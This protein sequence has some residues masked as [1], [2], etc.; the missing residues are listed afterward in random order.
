MK[1]WALLSVLWLAG[2]WA[3]ELETRYQYWWLKGPEVKSWRHDLLGTINLP[4]PH[5]LLFGV[6]HFERFREEDRQI[7][8]GW[9]RKT[10]SGYWELTHADGGHNKVLA[11][12]DTQLTHGGPLGHGFDGQINLKAQGYDTNDLHM[13][14]VGLNKEFPGGSFIYTGLGGGRATFQS[15]GETQDVWGA[16]VRAGRYQQDN[17]KWWVMG[18][19]G[20]EAQPLVVLGLTRPLRFVSYGVG[21]EKNLG[22]TWRASL[23]FDRTY[24]PSVATRMDSVTGRLIWDWGR[25]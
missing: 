3:H 15:P 18:A 7:L 17:Y 8:L 20:E 1:R 2:A 11:I 4:G 25:P 6:T 12:R 19:R 13:A 21:G 10:M 22:T 9:R 5:H 24:Y 16:N 14:S 23:D